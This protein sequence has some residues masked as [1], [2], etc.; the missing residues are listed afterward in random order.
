[1]SDATHKEFNLDSNHDLTYY[2]HKWD[3]TIRSLIAECI[4]YYDFN[5]SMDALETAGGYAQSVVPADIPLT[6]SDIS[7]Y[8]AENLV[9]PDDLIEYKKNFDVQSLIDKYHQG[10]YNFTTQHRRLHQNGNYF[11]AERNI[12]LFIDPQNDNIHCTIMIRKVAD[13]IARMKEELK[14]GAHELIS[15]SVPGGI[16][17]MYNLPNYPVYYINEHMLNF[18]GYEYDEF[19]SATNLETDKIIH[20]DDVHRTGRA[21]TQACRKNES[22][23]LQIRIIKKDKSVGWVIIRGKK[24][25][26]ANSSNQLICHFTDITKMVSLQDE[27]QQAAMA[28]A[29]ASKMKSAFLANMSHEIRTP[30]NGIIGF[31]ELA[32]EEANLSKT[33][34]DYLEKVKVSANGLLAIVN[35][36]LDISK[37]EAGKV[38]LEKVD[39]SLHDIFKHCEH[40]NRIKAEEKGIELYFGHEPFAWIKLKSDPNKITQIINNLLSN[41][42]K[43]THQ[44]SVKLEAALVASYEKM[45]EIRFTIKDTGIGMTKEQLTYVFTPFRQADQTTTRRYGGTGLGLSI[46]R[47]MIALMGGEL[48]TESKLGVGTTFT[49][50]LTFETVD[51]VT[52]P[53]KK[54]ADTSVK[55]PHFKG[56]VLVCEDN[57]INQQVIV[58]HLSRIGLKTFIAANGQCAVDM[59]TERLMLNKSFDLIFMDIHMPVMDGIEATH[60]LL[61]LG[62]TTPIIALTANAMKR[63]RESYLTLGMSDYIS[64]PFYAQE[65]WACVLKYMTPVSMEESNPKAAII[66]AINTQKAVINEELGLENAVFDKKLYQKLKHNFY[67]DNAKRYHEF[68]GYINEANIAAARK[69]AHSLKSSSAWIG[70]LDLSALAAELEACLLEERLC[71]DEQLAAL[72]EELTNVLKELKPK[73]RGG[74]NFSNK[75]DDRNTAVLKLYDKLIPLIKCGDAACLEL[76]PE[77]DDTFAE[78]GTYRDELIEQI[79]EYDFEKALLTLE[80][81]R[82]RSGLLA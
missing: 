80:Q 49:F 39:F 78:F 32:Q 36:I 14:A 2:F 35:D 76:L 19:M 47:D 15:A 1:M 22:F 50:T 30:M 66:E 82:E 33:T 63:D 38:E 5:L 68:A 74:V 79:E 73:A 75:N 46:T 69:V 4:H 64:K 42:I 52:K 37:I 71:S 41:A 59:I 77:I 31:I 72:K 16:I 20:P 54:V 65:L 60:K 29:E 62:I 21:I 40:L 9:H 45:V 26:E 12:Q 27:L 43:F 6:F 17:G 55:K 51:D 56:E 70:A 34:R 25:Q 18:L 57:I 81:I 10:E 61:S 67:L 3:P 24:N 7:R 11:W 28:A 44:G 23:E 58:E 48:I 8:I 53:K 13:T